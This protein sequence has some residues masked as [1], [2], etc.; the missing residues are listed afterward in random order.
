MTP[1]EGP[2]AL[3]R[4]P[5]VIRFRVKVERGAKGD[6]VTEGRGADNANV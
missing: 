1:K 4:P 5:Q 2:L 3:D 6:K